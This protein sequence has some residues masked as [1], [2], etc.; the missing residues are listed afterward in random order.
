MQNALH[1]NSA[2]HIILSGGDLSTHTQQQRPN[3]DLS[4]LVRVTEVLAG[5]TRHDLR[6]VQETDARHPVEYP[7]QQ[8]VQIRLSHLVRNRLVNRLRL[9]EI[10]F[11]G[12]VNCVHRRFRAGHR[13]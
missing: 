10:E 4:P 9:D 13:Q 12:D 7:S 11:S 8:L 2:N 5:I 6:V 1:G 3:F